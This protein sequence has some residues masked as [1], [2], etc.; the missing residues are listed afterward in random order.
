M[1]MNT[2]AREDADVR[3]FSFKVKIDFIMGHAIPTACVIF[4]LLKNHSSWI[5]DVV[6]LI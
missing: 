4:V 3:L 6:A 1:F 2:T 5:S